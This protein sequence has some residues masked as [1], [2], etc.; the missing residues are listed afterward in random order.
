MVL[1][2]MTHHQNAGTY[3][4][5]VHQ[6]FSMLHI[7]GEGLFNEDVVVCQE[8]LAH[9]RIVGDGRGTDHH[10]LKIGPREHCL[11]GVVS[12]HAMPGFFGRFSSRLAQIAAGPQITIR[13]LVKAPAHIPSPGTKADDSNSYFSHSVSLLNDSDGLLPWLRDR[14]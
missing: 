12:L 5:H 6:L 14:G 13:Q 1:K 8:R 3:R 4:A 2:Q 11:N 10:R 9:E 7:Q